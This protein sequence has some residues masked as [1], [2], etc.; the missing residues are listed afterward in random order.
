MIKMTNLGR[1]LVVDDKKINRES[2]QCL[3]NLGYDVETV[4]TFQEAA[5]RFGKVEF[6]LGKL[7]YDKMQNPGYEAILTDLMLPLGE[8]I[9][10]D[11]YC[12]DPAKKI[13][14]GYTLAFM[15]AR[16]KIPNVGIMSDFATTEIVADSER[17]PTRGS[18][19]SS[20][21]LLCKYYKEPRFYSD[22]D[23]I[24]KETPPVIRLED[25]KLMV[26]DE[27]DFCSLYERID[28]SFNEN[29]AD[30]RAEAIEWIYNKTGRTKLNPYI[31]VAKN[32]K[33]L[34]EALVTSK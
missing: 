17:R 25:S 20:F 1:I 15:A 31:Q 5:D 19:E 11:K 16:N 24:L 4:G 7:Q 6:R 26:C 23:I 18:F 21:D 8:G 28:G 3:A 12:E 33:A 32:W 30:A 2:A 13:P 29:Y 22:G 27:S 14:S 34:L 10:S 9:F